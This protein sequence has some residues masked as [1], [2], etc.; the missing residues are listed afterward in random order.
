M[1]W[2]DIPKEIWLRRAGLGQAGIN[3]E[4]SSAL[5]WVV[6]KLQFCPRITS[7]TS[8]GIWDLALC[9][10]GSAIHTLASCFRSQNIQLWENQVSFPL[11]ETL[12]NISVHIKYQWQEGQ[13]ESQAAFART[14]VFPVRQPSMLNRGLCS[15][16]LQMAG[17]CSAGL[18]VS[19]RSVD[20]WLLGQLLH[21]YTYIF[22]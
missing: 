19:G 4:E 22:M 11:F 12:L 5:Q 21:I 1:S 18:T 13:Q 17:P 3:T 9:V 14:D 2:N 6:R 16:P 20:L 7:L 10:G 8:C 15:H